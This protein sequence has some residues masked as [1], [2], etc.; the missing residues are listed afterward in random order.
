MRVSSRRIL[1][2]D[3]QPTG[4]GCYLSLALLV[5][6]LGALARWEPWSILMFATIGLAF[7]GMEA[8][9]RRKLRRMA[10]DRAGES[11]CTFARSFDCRSID[12]RIIRVTHEE[13]MAANGG[14]CP[15]RTSDRLSEH[16]GI[17]LEDLDDLAG[18]I[19][20][21]A[22]RSLDRWAENP[23]VGKVETAADL[24]HFLSNQPLIVDR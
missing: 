1:P 12:T 2:R 17:V 19:A 9:R 8:E 5:A 16:F 20:R 15:I 6:G 4:V 23:L 7:A 22:G 21:R 18:E 11:I 10:A 3:D 13:L 24:V 14:L